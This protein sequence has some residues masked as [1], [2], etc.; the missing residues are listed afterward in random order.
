VFV[1]CFAVLGEMLHPKRFAGIFSASP[2]V[3][4]AKRA[5]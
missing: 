2:A 1:A 4:L 3:A 5:P